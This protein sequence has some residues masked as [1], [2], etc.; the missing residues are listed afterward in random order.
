MD[1]FW[2]VCDV[3]TNRKLYVSYLTTDEL[4]RAI[5]EA[6][7]RMLLKRHARD[8]E[9]AHLWQDILAD[10]RSELGGRQLELLAKPVEGTEPAP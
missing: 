3:F 7:A 10:L 6:E 1:D 2:Q 8:K 9:G 4:A 5:Q